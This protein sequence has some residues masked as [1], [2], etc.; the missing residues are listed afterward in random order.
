MSDVWM[1]L[2]RPLNYATVYWWK[3]FKDRLAFSKITDKST[4]ASL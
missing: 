3:N 2:Q 4:V 1:D